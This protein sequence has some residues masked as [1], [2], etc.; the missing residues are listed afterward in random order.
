MGKMATRTVPDPSNPP[1]IE[2]INQKRRKKSA[3]RGE[4]N[5]SLPAFIRTISCV[6]S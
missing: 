6:P 3:M 2:T 4:E 5:R 1:E